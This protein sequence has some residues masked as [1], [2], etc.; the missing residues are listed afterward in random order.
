MAGGKY[1]NPKKAELLRAVQSKTTELTAATKAKDFKKAAKLAEEV[2]ALQA[3]VDANPGRGTTKKVSHDEAIAALGIK[4]EG[5]AVII[6]AKAAGGYLLKSQAFG[7]EVKFKRAMMDVA[8]IL[9]AS[10]E[11]K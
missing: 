11:K 5:S 8:S 9:P 7:P 1:F 4:P 10:K 6:V 3:Q 2:E